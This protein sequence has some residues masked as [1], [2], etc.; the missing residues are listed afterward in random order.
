MIWDPHSRPPVV[1]ATAIEHLQELLVQMLDGI[2]LFDDHES[3]EPVAEHAL[4]VLVLIPDKPLLVK[5]A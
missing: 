1:T 3:E 5:E 2:E 4:A